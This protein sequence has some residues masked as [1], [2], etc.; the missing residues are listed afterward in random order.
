MLG[1]VVGYEDG[2]VEADTLG[3]PVIVGLVEG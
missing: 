2:A 3:F 1:T